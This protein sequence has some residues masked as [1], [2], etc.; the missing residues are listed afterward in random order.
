LSSTTLG[1]ASKMSGH[2]DQHASCQVPSFIAAQL[3]LLPEAGRAL[4]NSAK[5]KLRGAGTEANAITVF[6]DRSSKLPPGEAALVQFRLEAPAAVT[7]GQ[8][9]TVLSI[10]P[11]RPLGK[12]TVLHTGEEEIERFDTRMIHYLRAASEGGRTGW[13]EAELLRPR[14]RPPTLEELALAVELPR[15]KVGEQLRVLGDTCVVIEESGGQRFAHAATIERLLKAVTDALERHH[16]KRPIL[17]GLG[18][19]EIGRA[20]PELRYRPLLDSVVGRGIAECRLGRT[21]KCVHLSGWG[22]RLSRTAEAARSGILEQLRESPFDT[23]NRRDLVASFR[24]PREAE[25]VLTLLEQSGDVAAISDQIVLLSESVAQA[26][27]A[28][29]KSI[30]EKGGITAADLRDLL[31]TSRKYA[32][33]LLEHFDRTGLTRRV[34]DQRVLRD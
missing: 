33:A 6:L 17:L 16:R 10:S 1:E 19:K 29:R 15:E 28:V 3:R 24:P 9:I 26:E 21:G 13:T 25:E 5:V 2:P 14:G 4:R 22:P 20:V 30:T 7:R 18:V 8:A 12:A 23:P 32:I 31:G 27:A 34:G 11:D